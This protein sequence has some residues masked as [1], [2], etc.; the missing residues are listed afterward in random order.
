M[1]RLPS[2]SFY[3]KL[4]KSLILHPQFSHS[5][6]PF[7]TEAENSVWKQCRL[8]W[9]NNCLHIGYPGGKGFVMF[10]EKDREEVW[11]GGNANQLFPLVFTSRYGV[12]SYLLRGKASTDA[13]FDHIWYLQ[14]IFTCLFRS[15]HMNCIYVKVFFNNKKVEKQ[16]VLYL[17]C[18]NK[19][20]QYAALL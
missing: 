2:S 12:Y 6:C 18:Q 1:A 5:R 9:K 19:D 13:T 17:S 10:W 16:I 7:G 4:M 11:R 8:F 15:T 20:I 3:P 14:I